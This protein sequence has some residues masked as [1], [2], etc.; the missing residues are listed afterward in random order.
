MLWQNIHR[1]KPKL[2]HCVPRD[3][4]TLVYTGYKQRQLLRDFKVDVNNQALDTQA[5][6]QVFPNLNLVGVYLLW[7]SYDFDNQLV[8]SKVTGAPDEKRNFHKASPQL[9]LVWNITPEID[10]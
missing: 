9:G 8:P 4:N 3:P 5:N 6:W 1:I 2:I 10:L 7:I